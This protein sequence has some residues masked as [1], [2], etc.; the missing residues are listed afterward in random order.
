MD[1]L[2]LEITTERIPG[3]APVSEHSLF[4]GITEA[5]TITAAEVQDEYMADVL[6]QVSHAEHVPLDG[7]WLR[8]AYMEEPE[9][10][11]IGRDFDDGMWEHV[12]VP[13]NFGLEPSLSAHFG[14]VY[15]R[16]RLAT[17]DV[18]HTL[19]LFDAVDYLADVWLDDECLGHHEGYF[20][21]FCFDVS[22]KIQTGSILTVRVQDPFEALEDDSPL[23]AHAKKVIKGTL[24]YHDSRPGGLPGANLTPGWTARLGQSLTTGGIAGSVSLRGTGP[25]RLDALFTTPIDIDAGIVHVA[26]L[27]INLTPDPIVGRFEL[28]I[29]LPEQAPFMATL[30][31]TFE[32]GAN[33]L[34]V[35]VTVPNP[36]LWWPVSHSDLGQPALYTTMA[37]V[38]LENVLSD[39]R[40]TTFGMRTAHVV[41]DPQRLEVNGRSVFVQAANYIPRQHFA[42]VDVDFYRRDM[43]L[44]AEAHLN[45]LGMHGH[46]QA[47]ACYEAADAEGILLFQDFALQ[48]RYDSGTETNPGFIENACRQIAE[49][50]YTYWNSPSIVYWACHNEPM[51]MFFPGQ[52]PDP[53]IDSDNQVLDE[54]LENR[55]RQRRTAPSHSSCIGNWR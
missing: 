39:T 41:D 6:K 20:A 28:A 18:P 19:L 16:R 40:T 35:R 11:P 7:E 8:H 10:Q 36:V 54:A 33:R 12:F 22:G 55:L 32:P 53:A 24:K 29:S 25:I 45:S 43:R 2:L 48:W 15:Y 13:N 14:P 37:S 46:L 21:P 34:D 9:K 30:P 3:A 50:A 42:D 51:A 1:T 4:T 49:M 38:M 23:F 26:A 31:V 5:H 44:A 52:Q 47:P 17:L 27:F